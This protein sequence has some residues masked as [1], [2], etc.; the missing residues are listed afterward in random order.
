MTEYLSSFARRN[1][2]QFIPTHVVADVK[3]L[4][5]VLVSANGLCH[6]PRYK[7]YE[8]FR[9]GQSSTYASKHSGKECLKRH[10]QKIILSQKPAKIHNQRKLIFSE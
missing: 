1:H 10:V 3:T 7:R 9:T 2:K 5:N 4:T 8:R 6:V